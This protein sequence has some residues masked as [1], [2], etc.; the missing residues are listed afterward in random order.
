M[1]NIKTEKVF[2]N[3]VCCQKLLPTFVDQFPSEI[4]FQAIDFHAK[5]T[6]FVSLKVNISENK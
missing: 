1:V 4:N 2:R 6:K 3:L 5:F